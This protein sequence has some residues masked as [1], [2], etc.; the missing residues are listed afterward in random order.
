[1]NSSIA[2]STPPGASSFAARVTGRV[3]A[4]L[5]A[6]AAACTFDEFVAEFAPTTG[7]VRLGQWACGAT[8]RP[9]TRF[10]PQAQSYQAT[11]ALGD[12]IGTAHATACGPV[13]ALTAMLYERGIAV[14]MTAFHQ[15]RAGS[16]VATFIQGANGT[17][18]EWAM[19]LA[20]D[21][22]QSALRAVIACA[23][24]LLG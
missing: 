11:L 16:D 10:G 8:D 12:R 3:P 18:V 5:R 6:S 21:P 19:G 20:S 23:N 9:S 13:A 24:R 14:E 22:V 2:T 4:P 1:M 15:R 17:R 7:P